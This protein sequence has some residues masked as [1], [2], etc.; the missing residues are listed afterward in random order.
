VPD[1]VPSIAEPPALI[2]VSAALPLLCFRWCC[3][4][5]RDRPL[6]TN[7]RAQSAKGQDVIEGGR[8]QEGC[9][10]ARVAPQLRHST[11]ELSRRC[12]VTT[13]WIRRHVTHASPPASSPASRARSTCCRSLAR[14]PRRAGKTHHRR[15]RLRRCPVQRRRLRISSAISGRHG[16]K[17]MLGTSALTS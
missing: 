11:L 12:W 4:F 1:P 10:A 17:P 2:A 9:D 8:D 3:C 5:E 16:V 15:S 14:S 7:W 13:N 6:G